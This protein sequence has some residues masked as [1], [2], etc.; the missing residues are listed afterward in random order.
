MNTNTITQLAEEY[1]KDVEDLGDG[2]GVHS[3][4]QVQDAYIAG[5]LVGIEKWNNLIERLKAM[6]S[7]YNPDELN[8]QPT[9]TDIA[10]ETQWIVEMLTKYEINW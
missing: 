2:D 7:N 6:L 1:S 9:K 5:Y 4:T 10:A 8:E 3:I